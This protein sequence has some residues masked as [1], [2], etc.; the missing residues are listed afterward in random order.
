MDVNQISLIETGTDEQGV[1]AESETRF[2][3]HI[4]SLV[5]QTIEKGLPVETLDKLLDL[6]DRLKSEWAREQYYIALSRFQGSC[7]PIPKKKA[8]T[9]KNGNVRFH[10][11]PL[12]DIVE[13]VK[14]PLS[15]CGFSWSLVPEQ[16]ESNV[17]AVLKIHHA[18]GHEETT[19]FSVPIDT[20]E[21]MTAIQRVASARS[22]ALRYA[23]CDGFGIM[24]SDEDTDGAGSATFT[25]AE[26]AAAG[27]ELQ[28]MRQAKTMDDLSKVTKDLLDGIPHGDERR[29]LMKRFYGVLRAEIVVRERVE[30]EAAE[31]SQ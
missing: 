3:V 17:I 19:R 20:N 10:Y 28:Q 6:R 1:A 25:L 29:D 2:G 31:A 26:Y 21:Y 11:A 7:P 9:G 27:A 30:R 13:L 22:Y 5:E 23:F 15:E 14:G 12:D 16:D 4:G 24:T 8:V 18:A